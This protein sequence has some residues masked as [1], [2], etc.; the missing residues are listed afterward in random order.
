MKIPSIYAEIYIMY[1]NYSPRQTFL[2]LLCGLVCSAGMAFLVN[3]FLAGP[4]LG[5]HYDFLLSN[6]RPPPVS[7]EILI[8]ETGDFIETSDIYSAL[9]TLT[10]MNASNL[11][12]TGRVSPSFSPVTITEAEIRR[13]FVDE[14][15]LLS[16]NIRNLFEAIRS[17]S[18]SPVQAPGY[19]ER[20]VELTEQGRDRLLTA[21]IDRDEDLLRAVTVFE[22]FMEAETNPKFDKD[23]KLRRVSPFDAETSLEHPVFLTLRQRYAVSQIEGSDQGLVLWLRRN[24]GTETDIPMDKNG[25]IITAWDSS[26][27]R[28]NLE[29]FK[30]YDEAGRVMRNALV[31]ANE[32]GAFS[33]TLPE[34]S[35]LILG[36]YALMLREEMLK[37]PDSGKKE[38][39][40]VARKNYFDSLY[41][42]LEGQAETVLVK[43]YNEV[44]TDEAGLNEQ[45]LAAL[46]SMRDEMS[47]S[48]ALMRE[49]YN[50]LS[51]LRDKLR[52]ELASSFCIMGPEHYADYSALL[53]NVMITNSHIVPAYDASILFWSITAAFIVLL[54][55]FMLRPVVQLI[56]GICLSVIAAGAFGCVFIFYSYWIDPAVVLS[57]SLFG[58]FAVFY[59]KCASLKYRTRRFRAAYGTAVSAGILRELIILGRPHLSEVIVTA[60]A[61]VAVKDIDLL[62]NEDNERPEEAGK[63]KKI[64]FSSVKKTAF[65]YGA[66]IAGFE[67]NM[68]LL[69]F[70]SPLDKTGDPVKKACAFIKEL[71][72]SENKSWRF[73]VDFGKSAFYW[74]A[75]T[76]YSVNGQP[77]VRARMLASNAVQLKARALVTG[78]VRENMNANYKKIG[79]LHETGEPVFEFPRNL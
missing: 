15:I 10:E 59:I 36:D 72:N 39:W 42:F 29:V 63:C 25:N 48:F 74:T 78:A 34:K 61:V 56:C 35:P 49:E 75:E 44:I 66:V 7:R 6:K 9:L 38:A 23:G 3:F 50:R 31:S 45:G 16:T 24:D 21:L 11:I 17:G 5:A 47:R 55:V 69:C 53:A 37:T 28:I 54:S 40:I 76:G 71:I 33:S 67:G 65:S 20:L 30:E 13:R 62:H 43:G 1:V 68:V 26:F 18:V 27:R 19:V 77:A 52:E 79:S 58:T 64:F 2:T 60:A 57:S 51:S 32:L 41:E 12:L 70:G 8:I 14:Y 4:K 46:A 73:G 22:N